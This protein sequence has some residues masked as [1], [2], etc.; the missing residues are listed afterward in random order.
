[1]KYFLEKQLDYFFTLLGF[2]FLNFAGLALGSIWTDP[3]V[4]SDWY[5][6]VN[7]APWT[8]AGWVFGFSWTTI[9]V[10]FSIYMTNLY[11]RKDGR[12]NLIILI[13]WILNILWNPLFFHLHF[14]WLSSIVII[15]LTGVLGFLIHVS[16][17]DGVKSWW[18]L[19]PYFI[20][21]NIATSL[22]LYVA[23]MN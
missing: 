6:S 10:F 3:G 4:S 1:M 16:R 21:L 17:V 8:P 14:V 20:W 13:S 9:M 18:T 7:Q 5:N 22:N 19:L 23:L 11:F 15:L 12:Y 2:L